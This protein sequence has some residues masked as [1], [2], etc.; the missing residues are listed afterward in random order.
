M[1]NTTQNGNHKNLA[2]I[3]TENPKLDMLTFNFFDKEAVNQLAWGNM[4]Q[5]EIDQRLDSLKA[6]QRLLRLGSESQDAIALCQGQH[7]LDSAHAIASLS[8][9]AFLE[10]ANFMDADKA[11]MIHREA[12]Q[13]TAGSMVFLAN[14]IQFSA[15]RHAK[16]LFDNAEN[17][18]SGLGNIPS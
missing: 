5:G 12:R 3:I 4:K 1:T 17:L 2:S 7:K 8:E 6:Y 10:V 11:R 13:K 9:E 15:P 14:V 18:R 16:N